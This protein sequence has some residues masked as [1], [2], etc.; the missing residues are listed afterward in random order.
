CVVCSSVVVEM[1]E[2][3]PLAPRRN[4]QRAKEGKPP[5]S[6]FT[7]NGTSAAMRRFPSLY[8]KVEKQHRRP[9]NPHSS[10]GSLDFLKDGQVLDGG[11]AATLQRAR[12][13]GDPQLYR[14]LSSLFSVFN[15]GEKKMWALFGRP[16]P[17]GSKLVPVQPSQLH[18]DGVVMEG[19]VVL[20]PFGSAECRGPGGSARPAM[21]VT[22]MWSR[23]RLDKIK[24]DEERRALLGSDDAIVDATAVWSAVVINGEGGAG[25][26]GGDGGEVAGLVGR[27]LNSTRCLEGRTIRLKNG[28]DQTMRLVVTPEK[29]LVIKVSPLRLTQ[30]IVELN[31]HYHVEYVQVDAL[32]AAADAMEDQDEGQEDEEADGE[33]EDPQADEEVPAFMGAHM[34]EGEVDPREQEM[35]AAANQNQEM[36]DGDG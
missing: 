26:A 7:R 2:D 11:W 17:R 16:C 15:N 31:F 14:D 18:G 9:S 36:I 3:P 28:S 22:L 35:L 12:E 34:P 5:L 29:P 10:V 20:T 19:K 27:L 6:S 30:P 21:S 8:P 4:L 32:A 13:G 24:R 23:D 33:G 25:E 1:N